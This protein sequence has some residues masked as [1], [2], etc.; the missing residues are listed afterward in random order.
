[1]EKKQF[2]TTKTDDSNFNFDTYIYLE[3]MMINS[4][5]QQIIAAH[6]SLAG[7][8]DIEDGLDYYK[9]Y[10]ERIVNIQSNTLIIDK[11][12]DEIDKFINSQYCSNYYKNLVRE[13]LKDIATP[14]IISK[15][16]NS[17]RNFADFDE[18][19][20]NAI[21]Q[22][23]KA[24]RNQ[25]RR[26]FEIFSL[27]FNLNSQGAKEFLNN[28][29]EPLEV[30]K[31]IV[32]TSGLD[33]NPGYYSGRGAIQCDLSGKKLNAIYQKLMSI[34]EKKALSFVKMTFE[35]PTLGATEF[36]I[37][38]YRLAQ[39]GY[40]LHN[41]KLS[42]DNVDFGCARGS[43]YAGVAIGTIMSSSIRRYDE[44]NEIKREFANLL[45]REL[46]ELIIEEERSKRFRG[47]EY[48]QNGFRKY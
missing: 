25:E 31:R 26:Y 37:S 36:L 29:A 30:I 6:Q 41:T 42:G 13:E 12:T 44:T 3:K 14:E 45:P 7:R 48:T 34:D 16:I 28:K 27:A 11:R 40:N 20:F 9:Y 38:L 4:S 8:V 47:Y 22:A 39:N 10:M 46:T 19:E 15:A 24:L 32:N 5:C 35:M 43:E 21:Y 2:T 17:E 18:N 23:L 33:N 1:M